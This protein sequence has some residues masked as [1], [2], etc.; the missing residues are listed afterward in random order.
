MYSLETFE[1]VLL[2]ADSVRYPTDEIAF[3]PRC[4]PRRLDILPMV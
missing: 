4:G 1:V 3:E 2:C